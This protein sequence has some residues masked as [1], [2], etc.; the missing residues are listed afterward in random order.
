MPGA[1]YRGNAFSKAVTGTAYPEYHGYFNWA[2]TPS[3][4]LLPG[5][6][7]STPAPSPA[8]TRRSGTSTGNDDYVVVRR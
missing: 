2:G 5:S 8:R 7:G 6:L 4:T 1:Y 3:P